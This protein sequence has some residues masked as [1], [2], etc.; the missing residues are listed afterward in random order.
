MSKTQGKTEDKA[1]PLTTSQ[2]LDLLRRR[3]L[4]NVDRGG[5]QGGLF[6][7][8]VTHQ[9]TRRRADALFLGMT[10]SNGKMLHGYELKVSRADWLRELKDTTKSD[11]WADECHS[12]TVVTG[13]PGIV[14]EDELPHGYGLME[15]RTGKAGVTRLVYKVK[16][17]TYGDRIPSWEALYSFLARGYSVNENEKKAA[18]NRALEQQQETMLR[19]QQTAAQTRDEMIKLAPA[20]RLQESL[21]RKGIILSPSPYGNQPGEIQVDKFTSLM[22]TYLEVGQDLL[23]AVE[24]LDQAARASSFRALDSAS[25]QLMIQL[26]AIERFKKD[27]KQEN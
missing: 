20:R 23:K 7:D 26:K 25:S 11:A 5:F 6:Y 8:E 13:A 9:Y 15:A 17:K 19:F 18:V 3:L 16:P 14:Q 12:W 27:V 22:Q 2:L 21:K 4:D 1:S 10:N 24:S